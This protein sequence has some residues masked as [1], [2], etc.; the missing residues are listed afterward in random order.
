MGGPPIRLT[1][2]PN[3]PAVAR[4]AAPWA[5][6]VSFYSAL[7]VWTAVC[8]PF[9]VRAAT[10]VEWGTLLQLFMIAFV[11]AYTIYFSLG[12]SFRAEVS[13][14]GEVT[15]TS[16]RRILRVAARQIDRVEGPSLP[17][18][19]AR[20]RLEREKAYLFCVPRNPAFRG[21]VDAIGRANPELGRKGV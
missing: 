17:F 20:F 11:L 18:G 8:L 1:A 4:Y 12:L 9:L 10:R 6:V 15:F 19:F 14:T 16:F 5:Y 7:A 21:L 3:G 2:G 13:E